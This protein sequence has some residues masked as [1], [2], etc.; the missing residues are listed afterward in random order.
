M[1]QG[2]RWFEQRR[3]FVASVPP[4]SAPAAGKPETPELFTKCPGCAE[5]VFND[6]LV[7]QQFVCAK[8][9]HHFRVGAVDRLRALCDDPPSVLLHDAD[10]LARDQLG[11]IDS[12]PYA[13]RLVDARKKSGRNDAFISVAGPVAGVDM[14]IGS[15]DFSF[16]GGSMGAVVGEMITRLFERAA[17]RKVPAVVISASGGAR[18]Q[19]GVLSLMQMAKT[20]AALARLRDAGMPYVSVLTHPTTGGV[21]ASF[22]MLGDVIVAEPGALIGFAGPRV[23]R[24]TIGQELPAG[25]QTSEYLLEH[26]LIDLIVSRPQLKP[27]LGRLLRQLLNLPP[28]G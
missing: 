1:S 15:F 20:C 23:I 5:V 22:A 14:E 21:A 13:K 17:D 26:G 11:F 25:F 7:K 4:D 8:C 9:D 18:M 28:M 27:T 10:L 24:E 3:D 16:L 12:K 19:E 6:V 2:T